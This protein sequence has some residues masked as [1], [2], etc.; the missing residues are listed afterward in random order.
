MSKRIWLTAV[1]GLALILSFGSCSATKPSKAVTAQPQAPKYSVLM[2]E[3]EMK[4]NHELWM[5]DF[6][7]KPKWD[8]TQGLMAL[9]MQQLADSSG[10]QRY[11]SYAK[12][13]AD[14]FIDES[15]NI[16]TY[17]LDEYNIDRLNPGKYLIALYKK[18][19]DEKYK[20]AID[21]LRSQL[22]THPRTSEGGFWHKKM[23]PEQMWLDGLYMGAP[24]YAQYALEFNR[25]QDYADIIKQFVIVNSHT[26]N[27]AAGLNYHGW[28]ESKAERWA[29]KQTGT[30]ACFWA[31]SMGWF[32]MGL[33]DAL[34]FIPANTPE[35]EKLLVL[36]S[37]VA[38]GIKKYQD[39]QSG[40][41][42]QVLDRGDDVGNY[43]EA[44]AS[45]MFVYILYKG[46]RLG[47]LDK[48]YLEVADKGYKGLITQFIKANSDGTISLVNNCGVAGLGGNPY[49]DGSFDYYINEKRR[50]NDP[51][52]VGPFI[53]ASLEYEYLHR[54]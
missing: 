30:S 45:S 47:Y 23:Y 40:V 16:D 39:A 33:V 52:G 12:S 19:G 22:N 24:F 8:Y 41:W 38:K 34:S 6:V 11:Y 5:T 51:K 35:R 25:P 20:K 7:S 3:S 49:R 37:Q 46:V 43:L 9:A 26:F 4:R 44:S 13:F 36:L 32:G 15:G 21:L 28:D 29:N 18:T 2:A 31:R 27:S 1:T 10:D 14:K 42:Y 50:D 48:S 53:M 54:K 17:K